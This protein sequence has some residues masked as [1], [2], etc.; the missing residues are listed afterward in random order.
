[1]ITLLSGGTGTPKLLQGFMQLLPQREIAVVVNTAEDVWLP[2]GHLS[3]DVDTVVYTLAELINEETWYGIQGDTFATHEQLL[4]LGFEEFMNIGDLDR[5]THIVR[6]ELLRRG[7]T[8]EEATRRISRALGVQA[9][10]LPMTNGEVRSVIRTDLGEMNLHE[11]LIK[12]G[13][14]PEVLEVKLVGEARPCEGCISALEEAEFV[15]IGPSNPV[16]SIMPILSLEGVREV[17]ADRRESVV[18]VSPLVGGKPVSGPA[19]KFLRAVGIEPTPRGIAEFYADVA[20]HFVIDLR[21]EQFSVGGV[22]VH[23]TGIIMK[24]RE[25]KRRLAEFIMGIFAGGRR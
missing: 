11:F 1:M 2:H 9:R 21:D 3:P 14:A 7:L 13:S 20:G 24:T 25:D 18:A 10:V 17:L 12:H 6:G 19:D 16:T 15:V 23:R 8:L 22:K 5:A 4:R